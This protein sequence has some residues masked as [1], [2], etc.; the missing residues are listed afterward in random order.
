MGENPLISDGKR[1]SSSLMENA[2]N[3]LENFDAGVKYSRPLHP[4]PPVQSVRASAAIFESYK[5]IEDYSE[6]CS[7]NNLEKIVWEFEVR[8]LQKCEV[9][10]EALSQ[11]PI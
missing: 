4:P 1:R 6:L 2:N 3:W 11:V 9:D 10:C 8:N 5:W 7:R